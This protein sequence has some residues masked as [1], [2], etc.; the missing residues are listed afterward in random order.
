MLTGE[1]AEA[2]PAPLGE[3]DAHHAV[4]LGILAPP[5]E[6]GGF[7]PV[8]ELDD[9]VVAQEK[10]GGEVAHGRVA[11]LRAPAHRQEE[12]V[13]GGGD[14]GLGGAFLG[15]AEIPAQAG[16]EG[17]QALIVHVGEHHRHKRIVAR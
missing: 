16:A 1:L 17:E 14:A 10:L 3:G 7:G 13:L 9:T 8:D 2:A 5:D 4:V 15:P 6:V 11:G 12:L